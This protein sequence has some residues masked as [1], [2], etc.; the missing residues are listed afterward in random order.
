MKSLNLR[1]TQF[2][3]SHQINRITNQ[4]IYILR[5]GSFLTGDEVFSYVVKRDN[6]IKSDKFYR[7]YNL[8]CDADWLTLVQ[9]K[10]Y[11]RNDQPAVVNVKIDKSKVKEPG[12]YTATITAYR[13]D[14]SKT[15]EFDMLA[16]LLF[17]MKLIHPTII[18]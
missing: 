4:E 15:P 8:K 18:K 14:A 17:L 13:D 5:D 6:L 12:I 3:L 2:H 11:I 1:L 10:T 16:T 7:V 9:K